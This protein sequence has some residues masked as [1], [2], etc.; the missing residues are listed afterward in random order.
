MNSQA[1]ILSM[2]FLAAT[3]DLFSYSYEHPHASQT[4]EYSHTLL[5]P[6]CIS[7]NPDKRVHLYIMPVQFPMPSS[8][9][10]TISFRIRS[11]S[12]WRAQRT[13]FFSI[14]VQ[15]SYRNFV[16]CALLIPVHCLL[17]RSQ[18]LHPPRSV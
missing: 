9:S 7:F 3:H 16:H 10:R 1:A 12:T 2:Y 8:S 6:S 13:L 14:T 5:L 15:L 11:R 17:I 4:S 18:I